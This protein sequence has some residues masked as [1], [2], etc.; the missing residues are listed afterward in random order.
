[1]SAR[2]T[3]FADAAVRVD[4]GS[5]LTATAQLVSQLRFAID[6]GAIAPHQQLPSI[7]VGAA[8]LGIHPNTLRKAYERLEQAGLVRTRHGVGTEAV[9]P[10]EGARAGAAASAIAAGALARAAAEGVDVE[11]LAAAILAHP[12]ERR[13][14]ALDALPRGAA[15]GLV[16]AEPGLRASL[17]GEAAGLGLRLRCAAPD[18]AF[19]LGDLAWGCALVLL[20]PDARSEAVR[21]ALAGAAAV[22]ETG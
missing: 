9:P 2:A 16:T 8:E 1:M 10:G 4:P 17:E 14:S 21:R 20:G 6:S 5:P 11:L 15:V 3:R 18:D 19:E 22:A 12:A 13:P 7:R